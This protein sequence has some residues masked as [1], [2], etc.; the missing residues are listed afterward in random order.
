M[1]RLPRIDVVGVPQHIVVRGV[2]RQRCFFERSDYPLYLEILREAASRCN[3]AVHAYVL[4]TNHVH[5][6]ATGGS[7]GALSSMMQR[8]GLRYVRRVNDLYMRTGT[9]FE[10]RFR[11]S[12]VQSERYLLACMRYIELNP[13]RAH[14]VARAEDYPWSSYRNNAGIERAG[15]LTPHEEFLRLAASEGDRTQAWRTLVSTA[16]DDDE[17]SS[18]RNHAAGNRVLGDRGFQQHVARTLGRRVH[19]VRP[20]RPWTARIHTAGSGDGSS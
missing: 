19:I 16:P 13:V 20:G 18:I 15:W 17:L 11:G 10:G 14:I 6:L 5:L 7:P 2:D 3:A 12:L 1:A 8:I 4:M 9:L